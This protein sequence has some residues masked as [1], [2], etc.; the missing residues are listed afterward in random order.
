MSGALAEYASRVMGA[1]SPIWEAP[2]AGSRPMEPLP[3]VGA[4]TEPLARGALSI[5]GMVPGKRS[6]T[7]DQ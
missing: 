6:H 5:D 1:V 4:V 3:V 2:A 7:G